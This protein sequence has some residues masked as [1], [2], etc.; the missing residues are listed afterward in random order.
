MKKILSL[1]IIYLCVTS[2]MDKSWDITQDIDLTVELGTDGLGVPIDSLQRIYMLDAINTEGSFN[3]DRGEG[4]TQQYFAYSETNE[5]V[6]FERPQDDDIVVGQPIKV[7]P[8]DATVSIPFNYNERITPDSTFLIHR[9]TTLR[10]YVQN[11]NDFTLNFQVDGSTAKTHLDNIVPQE[12]IAAYTP[13]LGYAIQQERFEPY[14]WYVEGASMHKDTPFQKFLPTLPRKLNLTL[15][16]VTITLNERQAEKM[17]QY[18]PGTQFSLPF[19]A[20]IF[21]PIYSA[22]ASAFTYDDKVVNI[23]EKVEKT[24]IISAKGLRVEADMRNT[25]P[26]NVATSLVVK[27]KNGEELKDVVVTTEVVKAGT[28]DSPTVSH[29]TFTLKFNDPTDITRVDALYIHVCGHGEKSL[30][31]EP[32][33]TTQYVDIYNLH[34]YLTGSVILN[35]ND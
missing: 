18:A 21:L 26:L 35:L 20:A 16:D 8:I 1:L 13:L 27:D 29:V 34:A 17:R 2:C 5:V 23:A 19:H 14:S 28:L 4:C 24:K 30:L 25:V 3:S 7:T 33:L 12:T 32:L 9:K 31:A 15:H 11:G 22:M 6:A 10:Y